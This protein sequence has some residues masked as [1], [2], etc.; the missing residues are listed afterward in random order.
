[1]QVA[2]GYRYRFEKPLD[3]YAVDADLNLWLGS[4]MLVSGAY[5]YARSLGTGDVPERE[6][7][8]HEAGPVLTYRVDDRLD[9][10]AGSLYTLAGKNV[11][12]TD[13]Y[14]VGLAVKRTTLNRLQGFLGG[15][16]RP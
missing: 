5:A 3:E 6:F 15:T 16:R 12:R 2:S 1:V 14:F 13:H 11:L 8:F 7:M 4:S 9:V 10:F